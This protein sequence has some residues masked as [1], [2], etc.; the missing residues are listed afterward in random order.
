MRRNVRRRRVR[1]EKAANAVWKICKQLGGGDG[2]STTNANH[3]T[4]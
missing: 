1:R 4:I 2:G 3:K